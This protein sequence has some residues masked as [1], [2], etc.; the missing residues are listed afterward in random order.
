MKLLLAGLLTLGL[1]WNMH[2]QVGRTGAFRAAAA[3][4][5]M[6][7]AGG[8]GGGSTN[9]TLCQDNA[10]PLGDVTV[11]LTVSTNFTANLTNGHAVVA[12]VVWYDS[13]AGVNCTNVADTMTNTYV[14]AS[15]EAFYN[16]VHSKIY[17]SLSVTGGASTVTAYFNNTP[18]YRQI[19][20]AEWSGVATSAAA[21]GWKTNAT[22]I[23]SNPQTLTSGS[24]TTGSSGDLVYGVFNPN[25]GSCAVTTG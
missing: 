21:D 5:G 9:L 17:Y 25:N 2:G 19:Y 13:G 20:I 22:S 23:S 8:G 7:V 12:C 3:I 24:T 11:G 18:N 15:T 10:S 1:C 6:P 14:A 4:Q 16:G